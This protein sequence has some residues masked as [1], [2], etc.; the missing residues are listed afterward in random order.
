MSTPETTHGYEVKLSL[1]RPKRNTGRVVVQV[2][3]FLTSTLET[4]IKL[5]WNGSRSQG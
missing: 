3:S 2:H 4:A 5:Q 1:S